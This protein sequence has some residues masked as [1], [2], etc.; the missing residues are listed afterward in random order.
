MNKIIIAI[1]GHSAV[2]KSTTA[3]AIA[4][5]LNYTY[6][7]S[8]AMYRAVTYYLLQNNISLT[9]VRELSEALANLEVCFQRDDAG[10]RITYLNGHP[11]EEEIRQIQVSENVS[12]V[13]ANSEVRRAMV[14]I[15]HRLGESKGI[16]MDGRD[17]GTVVFPQAELKIFMTA[18]L[19]IRAKR[20]FKEWLAKGIEVSFDEVRSN[21]AERDHKDS[22]RQDSPLKK[23]DDAIV[24]DNSFMTFDEQVDEIIAW[25]EER[26]NA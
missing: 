4:A 22:T 17:I 21:I 13:A 25:A 16:V 10:N 26:I 3:S 11:V 14:S 18:D 12:E 15:Q 1:D 24:V 7:D 19:E 23:A 5:I 6:V 8:G 20:R 9:D 2:G